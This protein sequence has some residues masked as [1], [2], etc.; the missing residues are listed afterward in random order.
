MNRASSLVGWSIVAAALAVA[1]GRASAQQSPLGLFQ[2]DTDVGQV[3][4][5]GSVIYDASRARHTKW[6]A[7]RSNHMFAPD[8]A[9]V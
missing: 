5:P 9:I 3:T 7:S 1:P 8:P 4:K 6:K 2:G